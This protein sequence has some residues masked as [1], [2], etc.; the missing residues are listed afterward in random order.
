MTQRDQVV[1]PVELAAIVVEGLEH[2]KRLE[3]MQREHELLGMISMP[4]GPF[5]VL[6][7]KSLEEVPVQASHWLL[8]H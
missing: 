6:L 4:L 2:S 5:P 3:A 7:L 8:L 1:H